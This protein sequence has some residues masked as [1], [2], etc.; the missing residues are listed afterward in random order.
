MIAR[1]DALAQEA[2]DRWQQKTPTAE[3]TEWLDQVA[4]AVRIENQA[5]AA[6]LA[7]MG[8]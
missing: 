8:L 5:V 3:S 2:F 1:F 6:Q 7:A 4:T